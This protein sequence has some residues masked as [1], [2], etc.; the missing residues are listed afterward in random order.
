MRG[1][2]QRHADGLTHEN[3]TGSV[4]APFEQSKRCMLN[5]PALPRYAALS[6]EHLLVCALQRDARA[7]AELIRRHRGLIVRCIT[8]VTTR[9][10]RVLTSE[11]VDDV[12]AEVC[13]LLWADDLKRLRAY[14]ASRGMKLASWLGLLAGHAAYDHLRR[15]RRRPS[16]EELDVVERAADPAAKSALD[17]LLEGERRA[18]LGAL[19]S[20]LSARDRA[21]VRRYFEGDEEPEAVARALRISVKTVYSKK[22]KITTRLKARAAGA[23]L[24]A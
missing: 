3:A 4:E 2:S 7:F 12:F 14:D 20:E 5:L 13:V 21:F 15:V 10:E 6:D 16:H 18:Q 9:Y 23:Q 8:R 19:T 17:E 24:A 22:H 1:V 11:C